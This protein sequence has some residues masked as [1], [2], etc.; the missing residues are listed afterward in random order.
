MRNVYCP[1][2]GE[3]LDKAVKNGNADFDCSKCRHRF[4]E[5]P[6][7]IQSWAGCVVLLAE[8][9]R[10]ALL[11]TD[12]PKEKTASP[13]RQRGPLSFKRRKV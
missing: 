6:E 5:D 8:L 2:Y 1:F 10:P 4:E 9:F 3:C 7:T 11:E 12:R 13:G